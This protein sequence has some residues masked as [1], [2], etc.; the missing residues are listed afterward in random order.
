MKITFCNIIAVIGG[1][2]NCIHEYGEGWFEEVLFSFCIIIP[3]HSLVG[4][5]DVVVFVLVAVTDVESRK[6]HDV[7]HFR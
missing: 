7:K 1:L 2:C 5:A 4:L 3:E 6:E